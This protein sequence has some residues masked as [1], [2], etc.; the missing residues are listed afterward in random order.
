MWKIDAF[1]LYPVAFI[2]S[3]NDGATEFFFIYDLMKSKSFF[4]FDVKPYLVILAPKID[5]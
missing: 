5:P 2:I 3:S 4:C 1:D